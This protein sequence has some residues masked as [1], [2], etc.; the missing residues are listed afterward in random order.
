M[1]QAHAFWG[2]GSTRKVVPNRHLRDG[3]VF[4]KKWGPKPP[5]HPT[6]S[7]TMVT[8]LREIDFIHTCAPS[9]RDENSAVTWAK[10]LPLPSTHFPAT[11]HVLERTDAASR[12]FACRWISPHHGTTRNFTLSMRLWCT[13][14]LQITLHLLP[15]TM[16]HDSWQQHPRSGIINRSTKKNCVIITI[17]NHVDQNFGTY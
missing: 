1:S 17:S 14:L 13:R 11:G 7:K 4:K 8:N 6:F 15:S 9:S 12:Y 5:R 16:N 2:N 3:S 10:R